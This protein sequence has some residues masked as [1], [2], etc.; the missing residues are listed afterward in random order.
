MAT[1]LAPRNS[2]LEVEVII[3]LHRT[4]WY[5]FPHAMNFP[6]IMVIKYI[7]ELPEWLINLSTAYYIKIR[8]VIKMKLWNKRPLKCFEKYLSSSAT[9]SHAEI[10]HTPHFKHLSDLRHFKDQMSIW[11]LCKARLI[12]LPNSLYW[13]FPSY[14]CTHTYCCTHVYTQRKCNTGWK[15]TF[16]K[17]QMTA[18]RKYTHSTGEGYNHTRQHLFL[19][20]ECM[21]HISI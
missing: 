19:C 18:F 11:C 16:C 6:L 14:S 17:S 1:W 21:L 4:W 12:G 3:Y 13:R 2:N 20:L 7:T 9:I 15:N 5:F 10:C 8:N